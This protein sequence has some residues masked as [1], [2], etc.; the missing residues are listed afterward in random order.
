[1][2]SYPWM[3]SARDQFVE[4]G[5]R[6]SGSL[7]GLVSLL[8]VVFVLIYDRRPTIRLVAGG[9]FLSVFVQGMLGGARVL[10]DKQTMALVHGDFAALV[11]SL[12]AI[13]V[14]ITSKGW[15]QRDRMSSQANSAAATRVAT[16]LLMVLSAQYVMGG[17]LRH[18]QGHPGFAW[19][20]L[21]HPWF[22]IAVVVTTL[23][24]VVVARRSGSPALR[25]CASAMV[26][27]AVAQSMIGLAT[28][29]YRHGVPEWGVVAIQDSLP[30]IVICSLHTIVGMTAFMTSAVT[31]FCCR[32]VAPLPMVRPTSAEQ[33]NMLNVSSPVGVAV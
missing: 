7:V 18:L 24:F 3:Q 32:A 21:V 16:V 31:V 20:R 26:A 11:F 8:L 6:L 29:Y 23:L 19:A 28:W 12:M 4:H 9:I 14:V 17:F 10:S 25:R 13:L 27:L 15:E 33:S 22:A 5:H 1:M 30:Q 2:L